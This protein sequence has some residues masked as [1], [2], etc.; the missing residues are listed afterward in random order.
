MLICS[1]LVGKLRFFSEN[2]ELNYGRRFVVRAIL[3]FV[4]GCSFI[5]FSFVSVCVTDNIL[6]KKI[7]FIIGD[8]VFWAFCRFTDVIL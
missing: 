2:R 5:Y 1:V 8:N 3:Q 7:I 4:S 6:K